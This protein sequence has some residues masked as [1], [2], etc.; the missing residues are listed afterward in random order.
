MQ[1]ILI[2]GTG[3]LAEELF[4]L[5]DEIPG[6]DVVGF[7]ENLDEPKTQETLEGLPIHWIESLPEFADEHLFLCGISTTNRW[8]YVEQAEALGAKFATL[9]HP[10][11]RVSKRATLGPGCFIGPGCIVS[12]RAVLGRHVFMNRHAIVGHHTRID[13]FVTLQPKANVAGLI[14]IHERCFIGIGATV[15]DRMQ[16]GAGS[17]VGAG[18]VVVKD[19]PER[20]QVVGVPARIVK[21]NIDNR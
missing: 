19:V 1:K 10:L 12:T 15:L 8:K 11:A 5:I 9:V 14:H 20:V 17:V 3:V 16:V 4:D 13:D 21:T 6:Y 2:L 7:V 18:A